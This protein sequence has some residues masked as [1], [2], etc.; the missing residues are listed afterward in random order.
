VAEN[1][2]DIREAAYRGGVKMA[3]KAVSVRDVFDASPVASP[4]QI[5][6]CFLCFLVAFFEGR[7]LCSCSGEG[8]P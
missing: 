5:W 3:S 4:C 1:G 2:N 7:P 6:V 8:S